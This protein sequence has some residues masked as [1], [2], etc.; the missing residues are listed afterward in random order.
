MK[1]R[2]SLLLALT[3]MVTG[4][5]GSPMNAIA[6]DETAG[7]SVLSIE[8]STNRLEYG[9]LTAGN[10]YTKSLTITNNAQEETSFSLAIDSL[11][12]ADTTSA[13]SNIVEWLTITGA[14]DYK[15]AGEASV[16][17]NIRVKVP[18]EATV[19]GQYASLIASNAD[20]DSITLAFI[21]AIIDGDGLKYGGEIVSSDISWFSLSPEIKSSV[22]IKNTGNVDFESTS[23][24][25]VTPLFGGNP[26]FD[27][28]TNASI[29]PGANDV[30]FHHDWSEAPSIGLYNALQTV[31]YVNDN[32][33]IV[34]HSTERVVI[35]CPIWLL[36]ILAVII[37]GIVVLIIFI[38]KRGKKSHK[39]TKKP[40]WEQDEE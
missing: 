13:H 26:I 35:I 6:E 40:S 14:T 12:G 21:S 31:T 3:V 2:A 18:K 34:E 37:I 24:L 27:A 10:S 8:A 11:D 4:V 23:K 1:K 5:F 32:G 36:I 17:V 22:T 29:Y 30:E 25:T 38:K 19:G 28:T 7:Q 39:N 9:G 33:E 20:G 15:L 16:N